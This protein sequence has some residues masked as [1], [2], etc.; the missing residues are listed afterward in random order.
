MSISEKPILR[1]AR[2]T[3]TIFQQATNVRKFR[4]QLSGAILRA[5]LGAL[6]AFIL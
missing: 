1:F 5:R 4:G 2:M 6:L 3:E